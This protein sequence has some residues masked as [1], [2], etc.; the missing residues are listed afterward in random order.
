MSEATTPSSWNAPFARP[1]QPP[2][3][4][5]SRGGRADSGTTR[6]SWLVY[7]VLALVVGVARR[8]AHLAAM[9]DP[10]PAGSLPRARRVGRAEPGELGA[11]ELAEQVQRKYRCRTARSSSASSRAATR[12]RT[13]TWATCVSATRTSAPMTGSRTGT[14]S[15]SSPRT[16]SSTRSA[17]PARPARSRGRRRPIA[18]SSCGAWAS[19]SRCGR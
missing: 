3:V 11:M 16:R 18:G 14:R 1:A 10:A 9:A 2:R 8:R 7:V 19:S 12:S 4:D 17:V 6:D 5:A 13:A 15:S